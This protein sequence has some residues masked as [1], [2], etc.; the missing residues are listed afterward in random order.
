MQRFTTYDTWAAA[1]DRFQMRAYVIRQLGQVAG[2][3]TW[4]VASLAHDVLAMLTLNPGEAREQTRIWRSLPTDQ[5]RT[6]RQHKNVLAALESV[7]DLMGRSPYV[8]LVREWL[9]LRPELP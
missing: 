8:D 7:A 2:S 5:V 9:A 6:L 4:N 1:A 3:T